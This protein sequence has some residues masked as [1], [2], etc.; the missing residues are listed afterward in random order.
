MPTSRS[1]IKIGITLGDPRGIGAEVTD[2]ALSH[3]NI[4][5]LADFKI[6]GHPQ[7]SFSLTLRSAGQLSLRYLQTAVELLKKN[8]INALVTAPV[9][10]EAISLVD[11]S[12]QG[13]TEFLA[14][15]FGVKN[16]GMLFVTDYLKTI[17]VT[18]HI[19]LNEVSKTINQK[20]I[21]LTIELT[22][23]VLQKQFRI[24]QPRLA[25][26]GLNPHAGEG[27]TIGKEE[28]E[29]I[30]P[31]IKN[32]QRKRMNVQ[33]PFAAD[34]LFTSDRIRSYDAVVAMYHDQGLIPIKTLAFRKAVNV[35]IGLPFIRTSPAHGTAFDIAGRNKADPSSMIEAIKL[36]VSL[37]K[38]R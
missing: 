17:I 29:K 25:V 2:K 5:K 13:H 7:K 23:N 14:D 28:I 6:I 27:G 31:A 19:P 33:G 11:P 4:L 32:A 16:V 12:F 21:F 10:K 20:N 36:A 38:K 37:A 26:C 30:I 9:S 18:R 1:R 15:A 22:H 35:T 3:A 8:E 34:T 24:R